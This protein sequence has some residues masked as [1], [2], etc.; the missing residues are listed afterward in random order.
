MAAV[1]TL[2]VFDFD[3]TLIDQNS[4]TFILSL[5]PELDY[6][7]EE[8]REASRVGGWTRFMD[9]TFSVIHKQGHGKAEITGHMKQICLYKQALKA[10]HAINKCVN[11][12]C[13]VVSDSNTVFINTILE[14]CG[15]NGFFSAV[16]SNPAH[17]DEKGRLH[18]QA[19]HSH[20]CERCKHT[21]NLCKARVLEEYRQLHVDYDRVVYVGDGRNDYCPCLKLTQKDVVLCREGY[22]LARLLKDPATSSCK[23]TVHTIDFVSSLGDF[24][25]ANL[26]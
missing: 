5:S 25:V 13:V 16:F 4:D 26:L 10:L 20:D 6:L 18:L 3:H 11:A 1:K 24:I 9:Y 15:V 2:F 14:E 17:F 8:Q 23:A 22:A 12:D 19:Y 21:P 7:R